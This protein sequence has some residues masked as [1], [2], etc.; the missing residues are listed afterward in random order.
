MALV[1]SAHFGGNLILTRDSLSENSPFSQMS[2]EIGFSHLRFPGG[3]VTEN[4]TWENGGLNKM[5]GDPMDSSHEN[6]VLTIREALAHSEDTGSGLT[7]VIPTK[8]FFDHSTGA[9]D[10]AGFGRYMAEME[11]ALAEYPAAKI[12]GF[13]LGNEYWGDGPGGALTASEYGSLVNDMLPTVADL[14]N[15]VAQNSGGVSDPGIGIQAGAG[16]RAEKEAD[17]KWHPTGVQE[18]E[19]IAAQIDPEMKEFVTTIYQH[20]YPNADKGVGWQSDWSIDP[21][22]AFLDIPGFSDDLKFSLSEFNIAPN[23]A[24]GV[25]QGASWIENF[26]ARI[27][28]GADEFMHWGLGYEH[29]SSKFYDLKF[30]ESESQNGTVGAIATPMGQVYDLAETHLVGKST[31]TDAQ[32]MTGISASGEL[33]VTGF[34]DPTQKVVFFHN[35]DAKAVTV[36]LAGLGDDQHVSVFHLVDTDSPHTPIYDESIPDEPG[37][38]DIV[39]ARGDMHLE[40]GQGTESIK[41]APGEMGVVIVSDPDRDLVLEGAHHATDSA[42]GMVDDLISGSN[43]NDILRGHAG[44]D[45]ISGG[46][47]RDIISG[48]EGDDRLSGDKGDDIIFSGEGDDAVSGGRGDDLIVVDEGGRED[49]TSVSTGVGS[50]V[51]LVGEGQHVSISDFSEQDL[52][53]FD[54]AFKDAESLQEAISVDGDDL[55]ISLADDGIVRLEGG[56]TFEESLADLVFDFKSEEEIR[57]YNDEVFDGLSSDQIGD[58]YDNIGQMDGAPDNI[59]ADKDYGSGQSPYLNDYEGYWEGF[60][61]SMARLEPDPQPDD[62]DSPDDPDDPD[63]PDDPDDPDGPDDP[64]DP[65]DP[66]WPDGPPDE[67]DDDPDERGE[68]GSGGSCFVATAAYGD[69]LHPD[70]VSL[71]AFRDIHLVKFRAGRTFIRL[72][73][74]VGPILARHVR[75]HHR[76]AGFARIVLTALVRYLEQYGL[77]GATTLHV[78]KVANLTECAHEQEGGGKTR[79]SK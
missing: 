22:K 40:A 26:S 43:G 37:P 55:L 10:E 53:G 60:D 28:G 36:N 21:M 33:G 56:A 49:K 18:S 62:P 8:Q 7:I 35:D 30:P 12:N 39:D 16:W 76:R 14:T 9:L 72:Y 74:I 34:A 57:D 73:W 1:T 20:S 3:A 52:I 13:E 46:N 23:S 61:A 27:D 68:N 54:G 78:A 32:A 15:E 24:T 67:P 44:D 77:T 71:R 47:G 63:G 48:G 65:D 6:Y 29:L 79:A 45:T 41:L 64:D 2:D 69:R 38:N 17:G 59:N 70:V 25:D 11:K 42:N 51:V 4:Q 75:P 50:D 66:F 19:E 5:F 31:I 58:F